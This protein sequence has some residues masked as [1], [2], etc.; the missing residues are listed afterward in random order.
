[1]SLEVELKFTGADLDRVRAR[2]AEL[3]GRTNGPVFESNVVY[4][5]AGRTLRAGRILL[6]LRRDRRGLITLKLP[7]AAPQPG[8]VKA[9]EEIESGVE[10]L[11]AMERILAGLG[12]LPALAYEKVREEWELPGCHVCLDTLPFGDFVEIEARSR[13]AV[14]AC[15]HTLGLDPGQASTANYHALHLAWLRERGLPE[16]DSFTFPEPR[17]SEILARLAAG[18]K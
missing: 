1:M 7:P 8:D 4:D 16:E 12:Y 13:E 14:F 18:R 10:D 9:L 2:L 6:R 15:A 3:G 11:G 17:R 5:D